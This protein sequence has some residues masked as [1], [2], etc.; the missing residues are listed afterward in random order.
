MKK[1]LSGRCAVIYR[2]GPRA[3]NR[4]TG[5]FNLESVPM[6][7]RNGFALR[8]TTLLLIA[9]TL[10]VVSK[11]IRAEI[12]MDCRRHNQNRTTEGRDRS[13]LCPDENVFM[14]LYVSCSNKFQ[15]LFL[16]S[17]P[18]LVTSLEDTLQ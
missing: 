10:C 6:K 14:S 15:S 13:F 17:N 18:L 5:S 1:P 16:I 12:A 3:P 9:F 2:A 7:R 11:E 4:G 8:D